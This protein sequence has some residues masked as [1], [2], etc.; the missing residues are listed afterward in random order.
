[1]IA[2]GPRLLPRYIPE[3]KNP[4]PG[5]TSGVAGAIR[6]ATVGGIAHGM[7]LAILDAPAGGR[8]DE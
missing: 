3:T 5:D 4:V 1:M 8:P 2:G 7:P 6:R